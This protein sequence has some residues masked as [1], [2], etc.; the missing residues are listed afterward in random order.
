VFGRENHGRRCSRFSSLFQPCASLKKTACPTRSFTDSRATQTV[1]TACLRSRVKKMSVSRRRSWE[2]PAFS[3]AVSAQP[4]T[5]NRWRS[6]VL[7]TSW[8]AHPTFLPDSL[9]ASST[10][11]W[12]WW[13]PQPK[14]SFLRSKKLASSSK[15]L[16][17][18]QIK[19]RCLSTAL[20]ARPVLQP[21]ASPTSCNT[22][23]CA[24]G[25]AC[26][27]WKHAGRPCFQAWVLLR[28]CW[29]N[30]KLRHLANQSCP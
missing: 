19:T 8:L 22:S 18:S 6:T 7:R 24:L 16:C 27:T 20:Q 15:L 13:I 23:R 21:S 5:K 25:T 26:S 29:N 12:T 28:S 4:S 1:H 3:R 9:T 11:F 2:N 17:L 10:R 30:L 14:A